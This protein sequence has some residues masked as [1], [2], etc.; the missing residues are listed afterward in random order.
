MLLKWVNFGRY[1]KIGYGFGYAKL[2]EYTKLIQRSMWDKWNGVHV[3][4]TRNLYRIY[5]EFT[6]LMHWVMMHLQGAKIVNAINLMV[7]SDMKMCHILWIQ[8][9]F[10]WDLCGNRRGFIGI[11]QWEAKDADDALMHWMMMHLQLGREV[12][13]DQFVSFPPFLML[14][15]QFEIFWKIF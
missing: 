5:R 4:F 3:T 11:S 13:W 15:P 1:L 7:Q 14:E 12:C 8:I 9:K 2:V 6:I 10:M